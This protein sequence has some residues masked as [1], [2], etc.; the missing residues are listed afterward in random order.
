MPA[1]PLVLLVAQAALILA[2]SAEIAF[3]IRARRRRTLVTA[4]ATKRGRK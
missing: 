2:L 1:P 3:R 4:R